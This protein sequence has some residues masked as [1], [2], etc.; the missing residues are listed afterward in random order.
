M[1]L[2]SNNELN[3]S[4]SCWDLVDPSNDDDV[5]YVDDDV[6]HVSTGYC[7]ARDQPAWSIGQDRSCTVHTDQNSE[8][9]LSE[10]ADS[11]AN[12]IVK[13]SE[14]CV[15][16]GHLSGY[17]LI[18]RAIRP[19]KRVTQPTA[20][21][22]LRAF[23]VTGGT[24]TNSDSAYDGDTATTKYYYYVNNS[25]SDSVNAYTA[26][27]NRQ[28][29][30]RETHSIKSKGTKNNSSSQNKTHYRSFDLWSRGPI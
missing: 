14:F 4:D 22:M 28:T 13:Q 24:D 10:S 27:N 30:C 6:P 29:A 26:S 20:S 2:L 3:R 19:T 15:R 16:A 7:R 21:P 9:G 23:Y 17:V 11:C 12:V 8:A 18:P 25:S 1:H 5:G